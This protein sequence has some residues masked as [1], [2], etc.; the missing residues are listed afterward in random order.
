M[1][2]QRGHEDDNGEEGHGMKFEQAQML[3]VDP[4][5]GL[6]FGWAIVSKEGGEPYFDLQG[7]HIPEETMLK[8]AAD[9]METSRVAKEMHEGDAKGS[10]VFA[11]P[12]T[13]EIAKSLGITSEKTG[14]L[15]AI[16]PTKEL[17]GK[18]LDG[19]Y[20]GFSI[21]GQYGE[22]EVVQ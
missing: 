16:K 7:D 15:I 22:V 13:G 10:V 9:F 14:L 5:L 3:K 18:F 17:L 12:L 4:K 6:V 19:T 21:G 8:A 2:L 11:F 1:P 20:T